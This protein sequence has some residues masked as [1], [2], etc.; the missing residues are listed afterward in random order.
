[1]AWVTSNTFMIANIVYTGSAGGYL[2]VPQ[3]GQETTSTHKPAA[4]C[5][6]NMSVLGFKCVCLNARTKANE[7]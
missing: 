4:K 2:D 5:P 7:N 6:G 1:M 3:T